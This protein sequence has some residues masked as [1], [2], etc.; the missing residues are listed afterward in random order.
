MELV[1]RTD[2]G[3]SQTGDA[4]PSNQVSPTSTTRDSLPGLRDSG[5]PF[6]Y[7][8]IPLHYSILQLQLIHLPLLH[9]I[10]LGVNSIYAF[11]HSILKLNDS[12][13]LCVYSIRGVKKLILSVVNHTLE[14]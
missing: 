8:T 10:V 4:A 14:R 2:G 6:V 11:C 9:S 1:A 5:R 3:S 12:L 13:Q 7:S